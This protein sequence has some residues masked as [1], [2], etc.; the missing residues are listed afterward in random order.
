MPRHRPGRSADRP[1]VC[2][3]LRG[4]LLDDNPATVRERQVEVDSGATTTNGMPCLA[5]AS[6]RA[7][8]P[9]LFATSPIRGD[10]IRA[11]EHTV[12][13]ALGYRGRG[14]ASA[15]TR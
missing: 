6:A 12:D 1:T 9:I 7:Y 14:G 5:A 4:A 15:Q 3:L 10:P 11:D 8:V 2:D 13:E